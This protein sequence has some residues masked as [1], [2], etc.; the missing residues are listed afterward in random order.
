MSAAQLN[1]IR[2]HL[3]TV[4]HI[5]VLHWHYFGSRSPTPLGFGDFEKFLEFL[6]S[7]TEPG[8]AI[9]VWPFPHEEQL[10]IAEGKVP[11]ESGEVPEGGAY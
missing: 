8:D 3:D 4:G 11:N 1:A 5:A 10:R 2:E 7:E 6:E 9:D